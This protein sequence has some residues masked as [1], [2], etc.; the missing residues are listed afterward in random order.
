MFRSTLAATLACLFALLQWQQ[1][2]FHQL[3]GQNQPSLQRKYPDSPLAI[4]H[5]P[6]SAMVSHPALTSLGLNGVAR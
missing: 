3:L 6:W 2:S 1:P 4:Q 5:L